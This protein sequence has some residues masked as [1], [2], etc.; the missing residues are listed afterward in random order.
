MPRRA[1]RLAR[2]LLSLPVRLAVGPVGAANADITQHVVVL[3]E[4]A[5]KLPWLLNMLPARVDEGDV[6]VFAS[7]KARVDDVAAQVAAA[8]FKAAALHG[9]MDQSTRMAVVHQLKAGQLHVVVATDVAARG[10]DIR[11]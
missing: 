1:E 2:D 3:K 6:L 4:D 9:D 8:G 11:R 7:T 5:E 10:L